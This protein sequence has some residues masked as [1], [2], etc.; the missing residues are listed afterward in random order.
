M[1]KENII[2]KDVPYN[3]LK[4]NFNYRTYLK[5]GG[6][7]KDPHNFAN[8]LVKEWGMPRINRLA[9]H[10]DTF[11]EKYQKLYWK[12]I[13]IALRTYAREKYG[14]EIWI[15]SNGI[16]PHVD[17]NSLGMYD[18]NGDGGGKGED[19]DYI[20]VIEKH[21][22]GSKSLKGTYLK[23]FNESKEVSGDVPLVFFIDWPGPLFN[24]YNRL[25][26]SEKKDFGGFM[27]PRCMRVKFSLFFICVLLLDRMLPTELLN[28]L[29]N[30]PGFIGN[31]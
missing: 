4:H 28:S 17:F 6:W 7:E 29:K 19:A 14:K 3:D 18:G 30:T 22:N 1:T 11:M 24:R 9:A 21:L 10:N 8:P 26:F 23:M 15:T 5:S 25:P 13:V 20:P 16:F 31:I 12:E 2:R 27:A